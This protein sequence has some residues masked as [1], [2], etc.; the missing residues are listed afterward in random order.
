M[1]LSLFSKVV[2]ESQK[3]LQNIQL[4]QKKREI[5]ERIL[6]PTDYYVGIKG[7][8]GVGKTTLLLQ[9]AKESK[10]PLYLSAD[11]IYLRNTSIYDIIKY[12]KDNGFDSFFIDEIQSQKDWTYSLK[13]LYDEGIRNVFFSGSSAI[14]L[15]K[16]ADLSRRAVIFD[17]PPVSFREYLF[18]K[19]DMK[20][21]KLS[22]Q[23]IILNKK[24]I[25]KKCINSY[26][27]FNEY[28][29]YGGVLY[30]QK[31]FDLK[32]SN[33]LNK[34]IRVDLAYL[35]NISS[36]I[37]ND[38]FKIFILV[39]S[40]D[41]F[42]LNYS[43]LSS[44]LGISKNN[45]INI[46]S[47]LQKTGALFICNPCKKGYALIRNEPKLLLPMPFTSFFSRQRLASASI[48]RLREE[49]FTMHSPNSCYFKTKRGEKTADFMIEDKIFEIGGVSKTSIQNPDYIVIDGLDITGN[50]I[51]LY[52]FGF[53][54]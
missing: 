12:A 11:A 6:N 15:I 45:L 38:I 8:R 29:N 13:T 1:E 47:D 36:N 39:S 51:P 21:P 44:A 49:F 24:E 4:F 7:L 35:R 9:I 18:I 31:E 30:D 23:D 16:G 52:L 37:E 22:I 54:Y 50:S 27:Y 10:N 28:L 42:E 26:K 2:L 34:L 43:R 17:L 25:S 32:F 5:W 40:T 33:S 20:F 48:G 3:A 19:K 53:L 41:S 14:E 46:L